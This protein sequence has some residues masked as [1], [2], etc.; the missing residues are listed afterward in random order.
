MPMDPKLRNRIIVAAGGGVIALSAAVVGWFEGKSNVA[1]LDPVAIPT[2]C[3]GYTPNVRLGDRKTDAECD[4]LLLEEIGRALAVVDASVTG[5]M[6]ESRRAAFASFVYNVGSGNF[7]RSSVLRLIN[8]GDV[9][10]SCDALLK[11]VNAGGKKL[12]GLVKRREA[13]RELCLAPR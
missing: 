2:I 7:R 1:Y 10:G 4:A 6:T 3:Y 8:Q 13:E 9:R 12:A 5:P 11:W